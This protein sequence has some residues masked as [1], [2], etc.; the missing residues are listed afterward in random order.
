MMPGGGWEGKWRGDRSAGSQ[1]PESE[2]R[3]K[4]EENKTEQTV[5]RYGA[6]RAARE[7]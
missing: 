1:G 5:T 7:P 3:Q 2:P 6:K 4:N